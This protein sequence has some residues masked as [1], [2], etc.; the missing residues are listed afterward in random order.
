MSHIFLISEQPNATALQRQF[1]KILDRAIV[2][3]NMQTFLDTELSPKAAS[4]LVYSPID[5]IAASDGLSSASDEFPW[6]SVVLIS[7]ERLKICS[8]GDHQFVRRFSLENGEPHLADLVS[9]AIAQ[10]VFHHREMSRRIDIHTRLNSL[11]DRETEVVRLASTGLETKGIARKL[12]VSNS[13]AEKHRRNALEKLDVTNIVELINRL[14]DVQQ[15][16]AQTLDPEHHPNARNR[17]GVRA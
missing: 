14:I 16:L 5:D 1:G 4:C 3:P 2:I 15:V 8:T 17:A 12:G 6:L 13:T 10:S 11:S 9:D 7:E